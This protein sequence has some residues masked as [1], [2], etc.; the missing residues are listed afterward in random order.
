MWQ[1]H[2]DLKSFPIY[3]IPGNNIPHHS[4]GKKFRRCDPCCCCLVVWVGRSHEW[5]NSCYHTN[6]SIPINYSPSWL[7]KYNYLN[8]HILKIPP[9]P[10]LR[11]EGFLGLN[12]P[13]PANRCAIAHFIGLCSQWSNNPV[14]KTQYCWWI[15]WNDWQIWW[16]SKK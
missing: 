4:W 8:I 12:C 3:L 7:V 5:M 10:P 13:T 2:W 15:P 14:S 11:R 9:S 16:S 1:T 6:I